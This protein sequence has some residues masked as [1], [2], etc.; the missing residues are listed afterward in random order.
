MWRWSIVTG[1]VNVALTSGLPLPATTPYR[2]LLAV[3]LALV[4]I[5]IVIALVNRYVVAPRLK[6]EGS[7]LRI[8]MSTSLAEVALGAAVIALVSLFALLDPS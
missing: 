6:P 7:A 3:K 5:M 1:V 2:M 8:L 4:A